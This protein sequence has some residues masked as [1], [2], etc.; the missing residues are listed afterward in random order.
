MTPSNTELYNLLRK[1]FDNYGLPF[2][3]DT[4]V[5]SKDNSTLF[6]SAGMQPLKPRFAAQDGGS[7]GNI[8]SCIRT[9]DIEFVGDG[10]HLTFFLMVG[11][12]SFGNNDYDKHVDLWSE[13]VH[14]LGLNPT[15]HVHPASGLD[16]YWRGNF[17]IEWD[18][19]CTWSDGNVGGYCSEMYVDGLEIGN[20]VNP[21]GHSVDVGFGYE[22]LLQVV[23][24]KKRVDETELFDAS[25]DPVSRDHSRTLTV[26]WDQGVRPA[27]KLHGYVTRKLM[28]RYMRLNPKST[29]FWAVEE[30]KKFD[31]A[32]RAANKYR[33]KHG[34]QP[35]LFWWDSFGLMPEDITELR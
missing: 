12:F 10:T 3:H 29:E 19:E 11:S 20:L 13:I 23:Q 4:D 17:P 32:T 25:L 21:M 26:M 35:D 34:P 8:Q 27:N 16:K 24:D 7:Y 18:S 1:Q 33:L 2:Q 15:I 6:V 30:R 5:V 31:S 14:D 9:N 28:R 22:R